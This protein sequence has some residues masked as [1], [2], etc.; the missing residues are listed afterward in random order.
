LSLSVQVFLPHRPCT[1]P[2]EDDVTEKAILLSL[3]SLKE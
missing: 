1:E 2:L 3:D